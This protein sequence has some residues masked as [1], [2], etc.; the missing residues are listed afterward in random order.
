MSI[1]MTERETILTNMMRLLDEYDYSYN[2]DVLNTIIDEWAFQKAPLI[3]AFKKHPNYV[4]GKFLI[5]FDYDYER[6]TDTNTIY[7]FWDWV[8]S[9]MRKMVDQLSPEINQQRIDD[10]CS[11][12]PDRLYN[13]ICYE[14]SHYYSNTVSKELADV[15]TEA[16]PAIHP[17]EGQ[18][19]TRLINKL[20]TYIGYSKH[21]EYN[22]RFAKY[23]DAI[24][25]LVIKRHTV[26]SLNPLDYLTMSFGNSWASCHTI[27]KNNKRGM[28]NHYSG[29]YSSGTMSYML[30]PS[31][32][33]LY[34][35]NKDYEGTDYWTQPKV[36][37]QMFHYGNDKLVQG[38]LYPQDCDD[39][40]EAYTPYRNIVQGIMATILDV[41]N[42]WSLQR[43]ISAASKYIISEG[44]HYRD[45]E[46]YSNCSLSRI[47][48][49][50]NDAEFQVGAEPICI[51]C[52]D[53]HNNEE[54]I[55]C[56]NDKYTC[57]DCGRHIDE[58]DEYWIDG[59]TYCSHC[60]EFCDRCG[61][62]TRGTIYIA[63][64]N[65]YVCQD[66]L[67]RYYTQCVRCG[68]Y[69]YHGDMYRVYNGDYICTDCYNA[70]Y[71]RCES[72]EEIYPI[73]E[74]DENFICVD[75]REED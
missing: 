69:E 16:V 25:P 7:Y 46:S 59:E 10:D 29:Q 74:L 32:M 34:T 20:L 22:Q 58:D 6:E 35:V 66:C 54:N 37:R 30:D 65:R 28:P 60:V 31:S 18:K 5:A 15:L 64:E 39:N 11:Y 67:E 62:A 38:R 26:L 40:E 55:N 24:N 36:N 21:P 57:N 33:V 41:P 13:I 23:A 56:C 72:C 12:L 14:I 49:S 70:Y 52:G 63:S 71:D 75:C 44:T 42:L 43:G 4:D 27:D 1:T 17:H 61:D 2:E 68:E 8:R 73:E 3:E 9:I 48:D 45:Y 50:Q 19:T 47:K 51:D 53:R